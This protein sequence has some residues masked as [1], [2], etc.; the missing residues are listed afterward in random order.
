MEDFF[1]QF[2]AN[3]EGRPEPP[4]DERMWRQVER[5]LDREQRP[6]R[7]VPAGWWW[8]AAAVLLILTASNAW[9]LWEL[10][11]ANH[12]IAA[13][14]LQRDT[15]VLTQYVH[16]VDTVYRTQIIREV[17]A[18]TF[19]SAERAEAATATPDRPFFAPQTP[20]FAFLEKTP[21]HGTPLGILLL[22]NKNAETAANA[23][24]SPAG[25][26][27]LADGL[28]PAPPT[29]L[30]ELALA[31]L[32]LA[33]PYLPPL[34][35]EDFSQAKKRNLWQRLY[36]LRPTAFQL[37][38][39]AGLA[40]PHG[41]GL[42]AH[43][44]RII[45]AQAQVEFHKRLRAT[46]EF[47]YGHAAFDTDRM[48]DDIGVPVVTPPNDD[49]S[50][51]GAEVPQSYLQFALGMQYLFN[52]EGRTRPLI[53]LGL[54]ALSVQPYEIK[55]EFEDEATDIEWE[56]ENEV[57]NPPTFSDNLLAQAGVE[58]QIGKRLHVQLLATY[59]TRL[60]DD[61]NPLPQ[62]LGLQSNILYRF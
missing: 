32:P 1:K 12:A 42:D 20:D 9:T 14:E 62:L 5:S 27:S 54:S 17:A 6:V 22:E 45:G 57:S 59:R 46:A 51:R 19:A 16:L 41:N 60:R 8:A 10:R 35:V 43:L 40:Y 38:P 30:E 25:A 52:P 11:R 21:V 48:G 31:E 61:S 39:I 58:R 47:S 53:G 7:T 29:P 26:G 2:K 36:P 50:F 18:P 13:L 15:V 56:F 34:T 23:E 55:Y 3:L 28:P 49:L 44:T 37:G 4:F 24:R 33:P